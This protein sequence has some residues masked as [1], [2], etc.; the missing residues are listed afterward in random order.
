MLNKNIYSLFIAVI[1][2]IFQISVTTNAQTKI[3][4]N[5]KKYVKIN[6]LKSALFV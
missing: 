3:N 6:V 5:G 2:S 1:L 4:E